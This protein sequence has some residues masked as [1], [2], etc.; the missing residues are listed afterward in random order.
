M[1]ALGPRCFERGS[2][3]REMAEIRFYWATAKPHADPES[4]EQ[5]FRARA[6]TTQYGLCKPNKNRRQ[7]IQSRVALDISTGRA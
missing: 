6:A 7:P 3:E 2:E 1:G 4:S 5:E